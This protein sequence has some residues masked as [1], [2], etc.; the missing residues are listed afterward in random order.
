MITV[1]LRWTTELTNDDYEDLAS[2]FDSEY[3]NG[4]GLWS[5][6]T[7]YGYARGEL[8]A[9]ARSKGELLGYAATA[10]R[11]IGV[12]PN[13]VLT[14]GTGGVI[15]REDARGIGVGR[16]VLAALQEANREFAPAEYGFLGCRKEVVPFYEACGYTRLH[17]LTIDVSPQDAMT[18]IR[19]NGPTMICAGTK[20]IS[21][22]PEGT[23][24]LRGLPW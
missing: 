18:V 13:E 14:A 19:S 20:P 24:N 5:P 8:H 9:L 12:G 17:Q 10:R 4:W 22:W 16:Q 2:L 3:E 11:F 15:T 23:I 1:D 6:K 7:G 21:S